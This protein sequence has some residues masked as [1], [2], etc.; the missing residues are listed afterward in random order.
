MAA[1]AELC[2]KVTELEGQLK[3]QKISTEDMLKMKS[4]YDDMKTR[5]DRSRRIVINELIRYISQGQFCF[6][7]W[8]EKRGSIKNPMCSH[9]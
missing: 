5:Y 9:K 8:Q 6:T 4:E 3:A 7:K 1:K 2:Q